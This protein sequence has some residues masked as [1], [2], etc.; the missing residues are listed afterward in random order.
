MALLS[1]VCMVERGKEGGDEEG[2][3]WVK[4]RG[5]MGEGVSEEGGEGCGWRSE[6]VVGEEV[7]K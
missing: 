1:G 7:S 3:V 5:S 6:K 2:H 4:K